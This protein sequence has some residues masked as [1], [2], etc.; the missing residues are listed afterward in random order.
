MG[1]GGVEEKEE[2]E[3]G[4]EEKEEDETGM[5]DEKGRVDVRRIKYI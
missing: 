1:E 3:T 2:E 4:M 5:E